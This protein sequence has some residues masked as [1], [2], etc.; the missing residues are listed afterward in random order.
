[1]IHLVD[2]VGKYFWI[3]PVSL[4][5]LPIEEDPAQVESTGADSVSPATG[6][7]TSHAQS[8]ATVDLGTVNGAERK[9]RTL[10]IIRRRSVQHCFHEGSDA[11]HVE[12][13]GADIVSLSTG[14][15]YMA[16]S[17]WGREEV[18]DDGHPHGTLQHTHCLCEG[19]HRERRCVGGEHWHGHRF[20]CCE[21]YRATPVSSLETVLKVGWLGLMHRT[22][23]WTGL[24]T[25]VARLEGGARFEKRSLAM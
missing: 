2:R 6:M 25:P 21:I 15:A 19:R 10:A 1:M 16:C 12:R 22:F 18:H 3:F 13:T 8:A 5:P 23:R 14:R 20:P 11:A 9:C 17:G 4:F 7:A 24:S